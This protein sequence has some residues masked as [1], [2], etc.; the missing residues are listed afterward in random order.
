MES[1]T[2]ELDSERTRR[3]TESEELKSKLIIERHEREKDASDHALMI[4]ELQKLL[5]EERR[6][7]EK[8]EN[9]MHEAQEKVK[10]VRD[11]WLNTSTKM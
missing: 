7:K 8:L 10:Q 11:L 2:R 1:L 4:R 9:S 3:A 6:A 5:S